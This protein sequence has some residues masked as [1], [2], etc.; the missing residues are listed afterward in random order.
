[1]FDLRT[2][3]LNQET[4]QASAFLCATCRMLGC[5]HQLLTGY[6]A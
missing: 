3:V 1:M 5:F 6:F 2:R 4:P